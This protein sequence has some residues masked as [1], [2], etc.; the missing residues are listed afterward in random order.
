MRGPGSPDAEA[1]A[2]ALFTGPGLDAL[3][4]GVLRGHD[5]GNDDDAG[6]GGEHSGPAGEPA[7]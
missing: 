6:R 1:A 5:S 2:V 4:A 7:R 3:V